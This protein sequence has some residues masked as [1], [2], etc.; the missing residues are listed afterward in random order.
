LAKGIAQNEG[1]NV[2]TDIDSFLV[3]LDKDLNTAHFFIKRAYLKSVAIKKD[4]LIAR[5]SYNLAYYYFRKCNNDS[6]NY[7]LDN[8]FVYAKKSNYMQ[9]ISITY[10]LK[11]TLAANKNKFENALQYYLKA[12]DISERHNLP[13]N[14]SIV[15]RDLGNLYVRQKD[16]IKAMDYHRQSIE[17]ALQHNLTSELISGYNNLAIL[18]AGS[19]KKISESY[20]VKSLR[21]AHQSKNRYA[22][23]Y[24]HINLSD[25]YVRYKNNS[26]MNKVYYHLQQAKKIQEL[27]QDK[28]LLFFVNFNF[29]G[30]Y[31]Q[32]KQFPTAIE[33]YKKALNT[34]NKNTPSNQVLNLY[35][36]LSEAY[37][38]NN[39]YKN[40]LQIKEK[41]NKLSETIF[42]IK[43]NKA[44]D[45]IQTKYEV[46]KKNLKIQLLTKDKIIQSRRKQ[47]IL[48]VGGII[49][50]FLLIFLLFYKQRV[51]TQKIIA[52]NE[53]KIHSQ[54]VA[55][56]ESEKELKRILGVVEGQDQERNRLA[57]DIHDGI[58]GAL[59]GIK[60]ELSQ[61]NT[62]LKNN[63]I[64]QIITK[65][66]TAFNELR[67][68]SHNL[69]V[70]SLKEKEFDFLLNKLKEEYKSRGEFDTEIIIFPENEMNAISHNTRYQL[71]RVIQEL[72]TNT[73]KHA[74]A[75]KVVLSC[76]V[77]DEQIN[78]IFEDNGSGF[79]FSKETGIGLRNIKERLSVINGTIVIESNKGT[80]TT[81]IIDIPRYG[82]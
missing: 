64:D 2:T 53:N 56:L 42:T 12:L 10:D 44:F 29:G 31:K 74:K 54:E 5:T 8:G 36:T 11:G 71:F 57:Q 37:V 28:S 1:K 78:I 43:K 3:F 40:A 59:A 16:S 34:I 25:L 24:A 21:L 20:Y 81:I 55:R 77:F 50:V 79:D 23:Y 39:D 80:G 15:L 22:E 72:F 4:S 65:M 58:G 13:N 35:H 18:Y 51:K 75:T 61:V 49:I 52:K 27:L 45:E 33:Y 14:K 17:N 7:Y 47:I 70:S 63:K 6:V 62:S 32:K 48:I 60:L 67:L 82:N 9:I 69:S 19:K 73:S 76:T 26:A 68:I 30:Y 46:D 38:Q 66:Q 41:Q